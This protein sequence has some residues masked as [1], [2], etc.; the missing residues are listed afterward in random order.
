VTKKTIENIENSRFDIGNFEYNEE[1]DEFICPEKQRLKFLYE[2]YE[3]ERKGNI[4]CIRELNVK[5]VNS[6]KMYKKKG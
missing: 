5:N 4:D 3:K 1:N 2:G 6:P